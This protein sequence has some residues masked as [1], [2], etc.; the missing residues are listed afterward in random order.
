[1]TN[2]FRYGGVVDKTSFCNRR[3][4]LHDLLR[5]ALNG[6]R[7]FLHSERRLGKTSL[8]RQMLRSLPRDKCLGVYVDLWPTEGEES[9]ATVTAKAISESMATKADKMLEAARK[10]FGGLAPALTVDPQGNPQLTFSSRGSRWTPADLRDVLAAPEAIARRRHRRVVIVFDEFQRILEYGSDVVER[11]LR[12]AIQ[13]QQHV[14]Y[15][16][17]GSRKHLIQRMFL[18]QSRPLYKSGTHYPLGPID[19]KHWVPFIRSRFRKSDRAIGS[20][21][22]RRICDATGGHPFY[23]QHLCHVV[24]ELTPPGKQAEVGAIDQAIDLLLERETYAYTALWESFALNQRRFLAGLA[25]E[26]PR[27]APFSSDFVQ[28]YRLRSA[29]NAQRAAE[30][31]LGRDVIDRDDGSY[32]I[33]DRFFRIWIRRTGLPG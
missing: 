31:L 26:A 2:P 8:V 32:L 5:A 24:W 11:T 18:D 4:E 1:M 6:E 7:F 25:A 23:T 12:S 17:L 16:F 9:F 15:L 3:Q 27:V 21:V 19:T 33:S 28:R 30:A 20:E 22:V 13:E 14:S 10:F 29:S